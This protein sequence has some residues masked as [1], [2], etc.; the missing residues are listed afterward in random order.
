MRRSFFIP[1]FCM[2][3]AAAAHVPTGSAQ[4]G[5]P[6]PRNRC[7]WAASI[8]L[9]YNA[10]RPADCYDWRAITQDERLSYNTAC[11]DLLPVMARRDG[12]YQLHMLCRQFDDGTFTCA[13]ALMPI[14][15]SSRPTDAPRFYINTRY[16][17][18]H[19]KSVEEI[20][21]AFRAVL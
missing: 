18:T 2:M 11:G 7:T 6:V 13:G 21:A 5:S 1:M 16:P 17:R 20:A 3:L 14:T 10:D 8:R 15:S 19:Q 4:M 9:C 12:V